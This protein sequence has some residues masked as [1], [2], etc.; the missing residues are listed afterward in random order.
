M[1]KPMLQSFDASVQK[2]PKPSRNQS[3]IVRP[4]AKVFCLTFAMTAVTVSAAAQAPPCTV[5]VVRD[6][7]IAVAASELDKAEEATTPSEARNHLLN[8]ALNLE[9]VMNYGALKWPSC[10]TCDPNVHTSGLSYMDV[11]QDLQTVAEAIE[12]RPTNEFSGLVETMQNS[13]ETLPYCGD[14]ANTLPYNPDFAG[15]W[16]FGRT[17][18]TVLCG[19]QN[20]PPFH[21]TP[22]TTP[23]GR[24]I[25]SCHP[26]EGFYWHFGPEL[27]FLALDGSISSILR[28]GS[29]NYWE[30]PY[31][32]DRAAHITH[33]ISKSPIIPWNGNWSGQFQ[34][35][36]GGSGQVGLTLS[37]SDHK[38]TGTYFGHNI[39]NGAADDLVITWEVIPWFQCQGV[40]HRMDMSP[41]YQ[42]ASGTYSVFGCSDGQ[43]YTGTVVWTR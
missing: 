39:S 38:V 36:K 32:L 27:I 30:G 20:Q 13:I 12:G 5:D 3:S 33:Y 31:M 37:G 23:R 41:D 21:L 43:D 26:N 11:A 25:Q 24:Q 1:A 34:N 42:S 15:N 28:Q 7:S 8:A 22:S 14:L 17:S 40:R 9:Q 29:P 19:G 4:I 35:S 18:G 6:F 16:E 2:E 10:M